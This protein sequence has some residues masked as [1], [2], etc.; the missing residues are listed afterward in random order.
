MIQTLQGVVVVLGIWAVSGA[1][2]WVGAV[3]VHFFKRK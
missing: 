2:L 3:V 1:L